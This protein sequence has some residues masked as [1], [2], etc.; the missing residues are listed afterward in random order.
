MDEYRI[1]NNLPVAE[2]E[3]TG[4]IGRTNER[5]GLK[6]LLLSDH[7]VITV[8]GAGGIGKTAL[9]M[10]V[11]HDLMDDPSPRFNNLIWV[12]LKT[13]FLTADGIKDI[14]D[15]VNTQARLL[16]QIGDVANVQIYLQ[17]DVDWSPVTDHMARH[18]TL[19]IVDNLETLGAGLNPV[20]F[21]HT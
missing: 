3:D 20:G 6:N 14:K 2:F 15:A 13:R 21:Q 9:A 5:R 10:R 16:D 11:C 17:P 4:F 18:N 19:L 1:V 12:S 7:R 8:V